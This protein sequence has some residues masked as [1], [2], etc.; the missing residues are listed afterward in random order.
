MREDPISESGR[1]SICGSQSELIALKTT[2]VAE[3]CWVGLPNAINFGCFSAR[4]SQA[5]RRVTSLPTVEIEAVVPD[6]SLEKARVQWKQSGKSAKFVVNTNVYGAPVSAMLVGKILATLKLFLQAPSLGTRSL[7][8]E[9]PQYL[10]LPGVSQVQI[11]DRLD[12]NTPRPEKVIDEEVSRSEIDTILDHIP[13]SEF[14]R[15]DFMSD[16]IITPLKK[17]ALEF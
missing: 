14:L 5:L 13:Q 15:E 12:V 3:Y 1:T 4:V 11:G 16:R 9:N 8:Y 17:Y 7:R 6:D 10:K 2:F